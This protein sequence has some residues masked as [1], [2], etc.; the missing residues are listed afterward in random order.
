MAE[1]LDNGLGQ[2]ARVVVLCY[3][4][5]DAKHLVRATEQ[6]SQLAITSPALPR[7]GPVSLELARIIQAC[8]HDHASRPMYMPADIGQQSIIL[9]LGGQHHGRVSSLQ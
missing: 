3:A 8:H 9:L 4:L 2:R 7:P 6:M 1:A 5:G